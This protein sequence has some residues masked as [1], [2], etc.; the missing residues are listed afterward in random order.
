MINLAVINLKTFGKKITKIIIVILAF[1]MII[2]FTKILYSITKKFDLENLKWNSN[3]G[4]M[5][6]NLALSKGF[7]KE[8][9]TKESELK[10]ILVAQLAV[11]SGAEEEIME[12]ENQEEVLEFEDTNA[13]TEVPENVVEPKTEEQ[14]EVQEPVQE[15]VSVATAVIENNNKKDIYTDTY[16]SVQIKNES[17]YSLTEAMVTPDVKY[18]NNKDMIIYHTHTCE[19]YTPTE[20]SQYAST[21]N[22]RT[23][24]L[25][26]S[27]ARVGTELANQLAGKGYAAI[28]DTT[29]HDYPAY[30]GSYTRALS[31]I[32]NMLNT[33]QTIDAVFDVHRDALRKQ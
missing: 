18:Q 22:Y 27:V 2:K 7:E 14:P 20:N 6:N 8:K 13:T 1:A 19:S 28:H 21:G 23:T 17:K 33:Y 12:K 25:N 10:K 32:K 15:N 30:T 26:Y 11:F 31:T 16:Q 9:T 4:I 29:Y 5:K 24:D 3:I